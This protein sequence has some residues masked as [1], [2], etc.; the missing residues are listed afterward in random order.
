M[1]FQHMASLLK[2]V[3]GKP[4]DVA[5]RDSIALFE[6]LRTGNAAGF[7]ALPALDARLQTLR[8]RSVNYL[9]H[10]YMNESWQLFWH[11]DAAR[12][13]GRAGL[14]FAGSA[15]IADN[16]LPDIFPQP[17]RAPIM[18]QASAEL[19]QDLQD[20]ALN[21]GFRR[22]IFSSGELP[23]LPR[24]FRDSDTKIYLLAAPDGGQMTVPSAFGQVAIETDALKAIVDALKDGP[25]AVRALA[26]LVPSSTDFRQLLLLLFQADTIAVA[27]AGQSDTKAAERLNRVIAAAACDGAAYEHLAA[28][29]LGSA[30]R[31]SRMELMLLD[32]WAEAQSDNGAIADGV[33]ERMSRRGQKLYHHGRVVD[34]AV[35]A[36][37]LRTVAGRFIEDIVPRWRELG[38]VE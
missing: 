16:L 13:L 17:L 28:A 34:D 32:S 15:T 38:V 26:G 22:D 23:P 8:S 27:A 25:V 4:S 35:A 9:V 36:D 19:R 18:E 2:K 3:T 37:R 29:R 6:R 33:R 24:E 10:E 12:E 31:V 30:I 5:I 1:P 11:S 7:R 14:R 20:F 21:Q